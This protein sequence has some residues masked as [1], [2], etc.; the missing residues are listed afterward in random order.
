MTVL[1]DHLFIVLLF[2]VQPVHGAREFSH[3]VKR[4]EDGKRANRIKFYRETI[5]LLWVALAVLAGT[6]IYLGRPAS[7]LG[8]VSPGGLGFWISAAF[9]AAVSAFLVLG[10]RQSLSYSP[11]E[12][13]KHIQSFG[14]LR[15]FMPASAEHYRYFFVTS[16]TAGIVE[17][18]IYRGFVIWYLVQFMPVWAAVIV[19]SIAFGLG[20]SYQGTGG[21]IR[22][23]I[24]GV[25][26]GALFIF[27][28]SIWVPIIGHFLL[29]ALQGLTMVEIL[30]DDGTKIAG[31]PETEN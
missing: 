25:V 14:N 4:I 16:V 28:G 1:I 18:I 13:Q 27:S 15:Y 30:R 26:F 12:K 22:V 24:I 9:V 23:T 11:E 29:D 19:S 3:F 2:V 5:V 21:V 20:H 7:D 31:E 10:W 6:W 8:F 17:E